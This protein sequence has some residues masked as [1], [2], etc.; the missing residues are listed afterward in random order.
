MFKPIP[1]MCFDCAHNETGFCGDYEE[2]DVCA[3]RDA[4][5][6]C[7]EPVEVEEQEE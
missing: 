5:G 7:W 1:F 3:R 4:E 2:N 6:N